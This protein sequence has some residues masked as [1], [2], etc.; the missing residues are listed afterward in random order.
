MLRFGLRQ[1][2][3]ARWAMPV[4]LRPAGV[5][6]R[7]V[8]RRAKRGGG[9][10][11]RTPD[12]LNAIQTLYQL[13]YTPKESVV[14]DGEDGI[15][16][17]GWLSRFC[18]TIWV[19]SFFVLQSIWRMVGFSPSGRRI[20]CRHPAGTGSKGR[21]S[22]IRGERPVTGVIMPKKKTNKS[23]AKRFKK[24]ATGKLVYSKAGRRHL[25]GDKSRGRKRALRKSGV[26]SAPEAKR[27]TELLAS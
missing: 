16:V 3:F 4:T 6:A 2:G 10:G 19:A 7:R 18:P 21:Y 22:S 1:P 11:S 12:L 5:A 24:T 26:L 9:K 17:T 23:A 15:G 14:A 8:A 25:Q 27:V 13:S 20:L